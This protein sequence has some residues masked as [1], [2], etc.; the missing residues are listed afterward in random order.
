MGIPEGGPIVETF[1]KALILR[2]FP[3]EMKECVGST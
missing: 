2:G 1:A 3:G